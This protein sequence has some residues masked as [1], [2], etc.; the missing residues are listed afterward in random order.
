MALSRNSTWMYL[1]HHPGEVFSVCG[2]TSA[3]E[4]NGRKSHVGGFRISRVATRSG[5]ILQVK[6]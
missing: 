1:V 4:M 3:T 2:V 6:K 5:M